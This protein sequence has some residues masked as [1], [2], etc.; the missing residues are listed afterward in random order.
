ML[1]NNLPTIIFAAIVLPIMSSCNLISQANS[2]SDQPLKISSKLAQSTT[3]PKFPSNQGTLSVQDQQFMVKAAQGG[4]T[5]VEL[6]KLAIQKASSSVVKSF[7]QHMVDEH[8]T[9]NN[10]LQQL[11]GQ[12]GI[13]LPTDIGVQSKTIKSRL[14]KLSG[15]AFD[16]EFMNQMVMDHKKTVSLFEQESKQGQDADLKSWAAQTLPNLQQHLRLALSNQ[17]NLATRSSR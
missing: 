4:M 11:A 8:T 12:K 10:Q 14:S 15:S 3:S 16:R 17:R 6:G 9:A 5:E 7:G 13:S 2:A 1:K